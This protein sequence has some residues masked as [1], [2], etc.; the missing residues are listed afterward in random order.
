MLKINQIKSIFRSEFNAL[1]HG[2]SEC[3]TLRYIHQD[4]NHLEPDGIWKNTWLRAFCHRDKIQ[5]IFTV[6]TG[7][8]FAEGFCVGVR[9]GLCYAGVAECRDRECIRWLPLLLYERYLH[10]AVI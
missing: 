9:L 4:R 5:S 6:Q 8:V 2:W 3:C 7:E 1:K 10:K